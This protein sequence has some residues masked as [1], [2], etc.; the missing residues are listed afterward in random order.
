MQAIDLL[1]FKGRE[2]LEVYLTG[3]KQRHHAV[4][5]HSPAAAAAATSTALAASSGGMALFPGLL[6]DTCCTMTYLWFWCLPSSALLGLCVPPA[7]PVMPSLLFH[8]ASP[9]TPYLAPDL[10]THPTT[11]LTPLPGPPDMPPVIHH[12]SPSTWT[13]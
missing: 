10:N 3:H 2:E 11:D 9:H 13:R 5:Q 7:D 6:S 1:I 8:P 4:S 12:S